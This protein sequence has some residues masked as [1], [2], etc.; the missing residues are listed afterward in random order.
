MIKS[1]VVLITK[2]T[3]TYIKISTLDKLIIS[4]K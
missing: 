2:Y 4:P 1:M 3:K